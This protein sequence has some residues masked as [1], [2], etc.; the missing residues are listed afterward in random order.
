MENTPT[1]SKPRALSIYEIAE[2]LELNTTARLQINAIE[3]G[4][5]GIEIHG[6][7]GY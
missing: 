2:E 7:H 5:D 3:A 4:F 1:Y 6:A